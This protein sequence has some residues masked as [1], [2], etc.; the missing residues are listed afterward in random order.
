MV[1]YEHIHILSEVH[2]PDLSE[3][4]WIEDAA[5]LYRRSR[6]WLD[7]Q[8]KAGKLT[9]AQF[10]GDR[11]IYLKRSELDAMLGKPIREERKGETA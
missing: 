2:M 10:E 3:Y 6:S 11:R 7:N 1:Y 9:Y 8:I 4:I 5:G